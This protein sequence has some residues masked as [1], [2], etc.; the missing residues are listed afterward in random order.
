MLNNS[1]K[2]SFPEPY[3]PDE[4]SINEFLSLVPTQECSFNGFILDEHF[5]K[6]LVAK[7][8]P[9]LLDTPPNEDPQYYHCIFVKTCNRYREWIFPEQMDFNWQLVALSGNLKKIEESNI[10]YKSKCELYTHA[11]SNGYIEA[12]YKLNTEQKGYAFQ[13]AVTNG[14]LPVAKKLLNLLGGVDGVPK[15]NRNAA[16]HASSK[17]GNLTMMLWLREQRMSLDLY[18]FH[19]ILTYSASHNQLKV[20]Q[21]FFNIVGNAIFDFSPYGMLSNAASNNDI[22]IMQWVWKHGKGK[23]STEEMITTLCVAVNN[24]NLHILHWAVQ[25][26]YISQKNKLITIQQARQ[27]GFNLAAD[28]ISESL[29]VIEEVNE[30]TPYLKLTLTNSSKDIPSET[31]PKNDKTSALKSK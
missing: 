3:L 1:R 26:L 11:A 9:F 7:Y 12:F 8:F 6:T 18:D 28:I 25:N 22:E 24:N 16:W 29:I 5:W 13:Y 10:P 30:F 15:F 23:I 20:I 27:C 19:N 17:E 2:N 31:I 4:D 21:F 14:N